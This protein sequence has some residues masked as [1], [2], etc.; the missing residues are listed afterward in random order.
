[1]MIRTAQLRRMNEHYDDGKNGIVLLYGRDGCEKEALLRVYLQ[2]K[3]HFYYRARAASAPEQY[4][5]MAAQT[6]ETYGIKLTKGTYNE[7][8]TRVKSGDASKLVVVIDEFQQ[9]VKKAPDFLTAI[10]LLK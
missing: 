10:I 5:Q 1:M 2:D 6:E 3:K 7:I 9:I 4:R 8:F